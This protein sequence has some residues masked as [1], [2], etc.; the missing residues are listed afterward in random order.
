MN[1][2]PFHKGVYGTCCSENIMPWL[3]IHFQSASSE[4]GVGYH[5]SIFWMALINNWGQ[6]IFFFFFRNLSGS[7]NRRILQE[8]LQISSTYCGWKPDHRP[9]FAS[10]ERDRDATPVLRSECCER[11]SWTSDTKAPNYSLCDMQNTSLVQSQDKVCISS[12][13]AVPSHSSL[14]FQLS[15]ISLEICLLGSPLFWGLNRQPMSLLCFENFKNLSSCLKV[16][17]SLIVYGLCFIWT[18]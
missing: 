15:E 3:R 7:E 17:G 6:D 11:G 5:V 12:I 2:Q 4:L 13:L 1:G 9:R 14:F 18:W 10:C 8:R 16:I